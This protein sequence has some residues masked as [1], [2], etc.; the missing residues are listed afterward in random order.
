MLQRLLILL[1]LSGIVTGQTFTNMSQLL[2]EAAPPGN[3]TGQRGASAADINNDGLVDLYH[4]NFRDPG[5][6]YL[7]RG[8]GG[9]TDIIDSIGLNEGTNMWGAAFGDY[10]N[11]GHLD[12]LFEDLSAPSKLYRN[13]GLG[14]FVEVNSQANVDILTLAQGA[15]WGDFNL[16]GKLDFLIVN[17]VG[18]NQLFKN[19]DYQVFSD[20]SVSANV[21]T[22]GNSYAISWGDIN[23][24]G[25]PDAYIATCH[26]WDPLRSINHLLLN[27]G[28]ETFTNIGQSAGVSDSLPGWGVLMIDYDQDMDLDIYCAN[29]HHPPL[30]GE[31]RLYRNDGNNTFTNVSFSSGASGA[32]D[33]SGYCNA[34]GDFDNDGWEDIYVTNLGQRDRLFHNNGDGTFTDVA[35]AAGIAIN[36]HRAIAV[37]DLNNDGWLDIFSAGSPT[38]ILYYNNGGSNHWLRV[39]A[40]GV[41][42]NYFGVG[43]RIELYV[44]TLKQL[45]EIRAGDSFC[46]Q[47][48]DVT[49]HFGLGNNTVID[50]LFIFWPT[51]Q[52]DQYFDV[53]NIDRELE[54][55]QGLGFNQRPLTMSLS[56][57]LGGDTLDNTGNP[58]QFSW[59]ASIDPDNDPVTY[60]IHLQGHDLWNNTLTDTTISGIFSNIWQPPAGLLQH[61]HWYRWRVEASDGLSKTASR[62]TGDFYYDIYGDIFSGIVEIDG[63]ENAVGWGVSWVDYDDDGDDDIYIANAG[64]KRNY[65]FRNDGNRSFAEITGLPIVADV[66][67]S[68]S[69]IWA[70]LNAD[71]HPDLLVVNSTSQS[72]S[73]YLSDGN[74]SFTS[75]TN[76]PV[77]TDGG[78]S[79]TAAWADYDLDGHLDLYVGNAGSTVNYL[80]RNSGF[81]V[82]ERVTGG[83]IATETS[84]ALGCSWSDYDLDGDPDLFV[85]T[86]RQNLLYRNNGDGTFTKINFGDVVSDDNISRGGSWG[87]YNNDQYPDLYVTN[88]GPN[89]LYR[90]NGDGT[91][92]AVRSG[93]IVNENSDSRGSVWSDVNRDGRL[94]LMIANAGSNAIWINAGND[95]FDPIVQGNF[96]TGNA[97]TLGIASADADDDGI[98]DLLVANG[99]STVPNQLFFGA[100]N[101]GNWLSVRLHSSQ[102]ANKSAIGSR[103]R[104]KAQIAGVMV[105]QAREVLAQSGFAGQGSPR[106]V[107]GVGD[108]TVID[109]VVVHFQSG[110]VR[111]AQNVNV[112]QQF[113][114]FDGPLAVDDPGDGLPSEFRLLQNYPNPF[115][116]STTIELRLPSASVVTL[117]IYDVMGRHVE[118]PYK[119]SLRVGHHKFIWNATDADGNQMPSGVYFYRLQAGDRVLIRKMLLVR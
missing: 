7:N 104:I 41:Q 109:S 88:L 37:A 57:P 93:T 103:V 77:V 115:N 14:D 94:D 74:G 16:D 118:T 100:G 10:D 19:M 32:I 24:D 48:L 91:F 58:P 28:D 75:V 43:A 20:I 44:D 29:S 76:D 52:V 98:P 18:P 21:Q 111:T 107:F 89:N 42:D 6:L 50:S 47:N 113:D 49:A 73:L 60:T 90:N 102:T 96:V 36:D 56:S 86:N 53:T 108:A 116:P 114:F 92:T 35:Q 106:L 12:I 72:N 117:E 5:R 11:D 67:S 45:R 83:L 31:N 3:N 62:T 23:N 87:D 85:A 38:N 26:P 17:D 25:Y 80:Y 81:G 59:E 119:A 22:F 63:G 66:N 61:N 30:S 65:L 112:N 110:V 64:N 68:S 79:I 40:R 46:S 84:N 8:A 4:S 27:N 82:F 97:P 39:R 34:A 33:E 13:T 105:D 99:S 2:R 71:D 15:A 101:A 78:N 1:F 95:Q 54:L 51:G 55:V 69:A 9:F 70:H